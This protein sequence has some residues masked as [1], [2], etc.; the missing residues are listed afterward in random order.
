MEFNVEKIWMKNKMK[1]GVKFSL[2]LRAQWWTFRRDFSLNLLAVYERIFDGFS[3]MLL[4]EYK[5]HKWGFYSGEFCM[6]WRR[7]QGLL[8]ACVTRIYGGNGCYSFG[9]LWIVFFPFVSC[10]WGVK[11]GVRN[12]WIPGFVA[13]QLG[14]SIKVIRCHLV[15]L[16]MCLI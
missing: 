11:W 16:N 5:L 12:G 4:V 14:E 8:H 15:I 9:W 2:P 6:Q 1:K 10:V 7:L 3:T 13:W